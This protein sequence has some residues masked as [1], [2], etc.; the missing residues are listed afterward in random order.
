[1]VT[2]LPALVNIYFFLF[3]TQIFTLQNLGL[4]YRG[5]SLITHN[6]IDWIIGFLAILAIPVCYSW[7]HSMKKQVWILLSFG[8]S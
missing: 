1:M 7:P 6:L 5:H 2:I 4:N 3:H 8:F